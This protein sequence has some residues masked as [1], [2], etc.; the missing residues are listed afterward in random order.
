MSV[1][2]IYICM[3]GLNVIY[4]SRKTEYPFQEQTLGSNKPTREILNKISM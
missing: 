4:R 2:K 3:F 1:V